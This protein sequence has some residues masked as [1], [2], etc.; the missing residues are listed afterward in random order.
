LPFL[1]FQVATSYLHL[2]FKHRVHSTP[3]VISHCNTTPSLSLLWPFLLYRIWRLYNLKD[4][5]VV[6][7]FVLIPL[8]GKLGV[9]KDPPALAYRLENSISEEG[10]LANH[11]RVLDR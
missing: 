7:D 2:G 3:E 1:P 5:V 4:V 9:I 6:I 10:N 11:H 8:V